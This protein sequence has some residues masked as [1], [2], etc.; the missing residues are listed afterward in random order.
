V[1][2]DLGTAS[3]STTINGG[4]S[5]PIPI[6]VTGTLPVRNGGT[7]STSFTAN[8]LIIS[9]NSTTAAL[10]T[11]GIT[12]NTS[13]AA[14][15]TGTNIPT[16]NTIYNGLVVVNDSAQT[17][18]TTIYAPTTPGTTN[19]ILVATSTGIPVWKSTNNGALYATSSGG[20]TTFGTLPVPQGGIGITSVTKNAIL[21]GNAS[22]ITGAISPIATQSGAL[23]ATTA[24]GTAMFGTLPVN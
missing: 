8:S 7:G 21:A 5:G 11:R 14:I 13:N 15:T 12:N 24:N 18:A 19:Q 20:S 3:T 16:L 23:Y 10:T 9:G 22:S 1:Y 17:R 6:G 4:I 2:T